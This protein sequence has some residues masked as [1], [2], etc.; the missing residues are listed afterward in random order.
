MSKTLPRNPSIAALDIG[1][2]KVA[3]FIASR[4]EDDELHVIGVGHHRAKGSYPERLAELGVPLPMDVIGGQ[5]LR[6]LRTPEGGY[7]LYSLGW[8]GTDEG[9]QPGSGDDAIRRGDWVWR[10]RGGA[11]STA[12]TSAGKGR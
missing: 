1:T 12:K 3:C 11:E 10:I 8:N 4:D 6:Y 7:V 9:G 5:P 2:T